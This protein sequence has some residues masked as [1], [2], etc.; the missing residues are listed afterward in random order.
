MKE[1]VFAGL[2]VSLAAVRVTAQ[3]LH[4]LTPFLPPLHP[5]SGRSRHQ[6]HLLWQRRVQPLRLPKPGGSARSPNGR[7]LTRP[8]PR[9]PS[10]RPPARGSPGS[11]SSRSRRLPTRQFNCA[12]SPVADHHRLHLDAGSQAPQRRGLPLAMLRGDLEG[13]WRSHTPLA[14]FVPGRTRLLHSARGERETID[15]IR[16]EVRHTTRVSLSVVGPSIR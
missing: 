12:T 7:W 2:L 3:V 4:L 14:P 5:D 11:A 10:K 6:R 13:T 16:G 9:R 8:R 15:W 1:P